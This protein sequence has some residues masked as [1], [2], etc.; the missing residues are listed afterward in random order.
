VPTVG[1][2]DART[3]AS[4]IG[5][6]PF[7]VLHVTV[8][9]KRLSELGKKYPWPRPKR[10]L[11]CKSPR[12]WGHGYVQRYF[13]GFTHPLWIKRLRCPDCHTVYTL[14]PDLFYRGFQYSLITILCSLLAKIT[15]HRWLSCIPR[16]NQ[17]YWYKGLRL[18][19]FRLRS[20]P[21]PDRDTMEEII[22]LGFIPSSHSLDCAILRL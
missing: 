16:Q 13:E 22:S 6:Y 21:S 14:R 2:M 10:C 4:R 8:D 20:V 19:T 11:S 3:V 12:I 18:Q 15:D 5:Y 1:W 7:V 17:Q 9:V